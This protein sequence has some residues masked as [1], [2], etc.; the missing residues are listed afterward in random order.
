MSNAPESEGP[1]GPTA[2]IL[3][4]IVRMRCVSATYNRKRM[5]L[6]PHIAY[7][8]GGGLY[9]DALVISRENMLAREPKIGTFKIDGMSE[10]AI[11]QRDFTPSELFDPSLDKYATAVMAIEPEA[12]AA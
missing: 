4:A 5:I 8:R 1:S 7:L 10:L 6:A 3:E 9:V 12:A 11:T 2:T